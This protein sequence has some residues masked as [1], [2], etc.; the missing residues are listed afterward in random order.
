MIF[1]PKLSKQSIIFL[2]QIMQTIIYQHKI[3]KKR[4]VHQQKTINIFLWKQV[5]MH[6]F[7][8]INKFF[9]VMVKYQTEQCLFDMDA[10]YKRID[11]S[12]YG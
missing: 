2:R 5:P 3:T 8:K 1:E 11:M 9:F 4:V 7:I 6:N 10:A 12:M